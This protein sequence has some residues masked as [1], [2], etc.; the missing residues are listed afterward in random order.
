MKDAQPERNRIGDWAYARIR[1]AILD[2]ELAPGTRLSVPDLARRLDISRSPA[3]ES[4]LRL[5]SEGLAEEVPHRGAFVSTVTVGNLIE[6]YTVRSVLEGL[7]A[8]LAAERVTPDDV[9]ALNASIDAHRAVLETGDRPA[10]TEA[11]MAFHR[12]LYRLSENSWLMDSLLRLQS[13][14]R[15]GM[16]TTLLAPG[17]PAHA[18]S[19]HEQIRDAVVEGNPDAAEERVRHHVDRLREVIRSQRS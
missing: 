7:A 13:L 18:L 6:I 11:D 8:R 16:R 12:L 4:I 17:S 14:V 2:G 10:I 5:I 9:P 3:R 19:E 15:L 1:D